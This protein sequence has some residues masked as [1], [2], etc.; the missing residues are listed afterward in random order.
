VVERVEKAESA[1]LAITVITRI[2]LL[3]GR[4]EF[5]LKASHID[6]LMRAQRRLDETN[7]ALADWQVLP[8][9]D[10]AGDHFSRLRDLKGIRRIGRA[11]L[12][13]ACI[14]LANGATLATRNM[15]DF[16]LVPGL[17]LEN[18]VD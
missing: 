11:D 1:G 12:L 14:V 3:R 2:E 18:W 5:L 15:R 6:Q 4:F 16:A 8:I 9:S 13:I 7:E 17:K 10:S